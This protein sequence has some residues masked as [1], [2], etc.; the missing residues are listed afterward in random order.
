MALVIR[1]HRFIQLSSFLYI[2]KLFTFSHLQVRIDGKSF[3]LVQGF[4]YRFKSGTCRARNVNRFDTGEGVDI[5][6]FLGIAQDIPK[7]IH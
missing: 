1:F 3:V 7:E 5:G 4:R 2:F 6:L